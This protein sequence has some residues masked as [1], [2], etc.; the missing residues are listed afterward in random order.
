MTP[1]E[2]RTRNFVNVA[3]AAEF[4]GPGEPLDERTVR[5]AIEQGQ[6]PALKVGAKTLIPVAPLLAMIQAPSSAPTEAPARQVAD[7]IPAVREILLG[8]LRAVEALTERSLGDD[9][10]PGA[11]TL[12]SIDTSAEG[13]VILPVIPGGSR[14]S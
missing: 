6:I 8:A 1:D 3:E 10:S 9:R 2:L 4:L 7:P 12:T 14:A 5:R 13:A 11:T